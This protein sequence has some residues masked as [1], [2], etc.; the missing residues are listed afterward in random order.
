MRLVVYFIKGK[1][2]YGADHFSFV[3]LLLYL[4]DSI[5]GSDLLSSEAVI[6]FLR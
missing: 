5:F 4:F 6:L 1:D 3:L 2:T